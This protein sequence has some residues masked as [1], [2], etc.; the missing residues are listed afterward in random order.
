MFSFTSF[1]VIYIHVK[2]ER[3]VSQYRTRKGGGGINCCI[4]SFM[5][6]GKPL[7]LIVWH[8]IR[9][10][11][12]R[13]LGI[14]H[15]L[16]VPCDPFRCLF[17]CVCTLW[18]EIKRTTQPTSQQCLAA[19]HLVDVLDNPAWGKRKTKSDLRLL[20]RPHPLLD[21]LRVCAPGYV[22]IRGCWM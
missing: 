11:R 2:E 18:S 19:L 5:C 8:R 14:I 21:R 12:G 10:S 17:L 22:L 9:D 16:L 13:Y 1:L 4:T 15:Y 20:R 3:N 6:C 7:P